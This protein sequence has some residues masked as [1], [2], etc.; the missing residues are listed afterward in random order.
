MD[1]ATQVGAAINAWLEGTARAAL[2]PAL[3]T[4]GTLVVA[5]P[6]L[7]IAPS[8]VS[9]WRLM[10]ALANALLVLAW[11]ACGV[12]VMSGAGDGRYAA[13]V[14]IPRVAFAALAANASLAVA[15]GL[16]ALNNALVAT[17]L[18][19]SAATHA[20][21]L[22]LITLPASSHDVL[23]VAL[24]LATAV[25]GVVLVAVAVI[26]D[27]VLI[28]A[29]A[30]APLALATSALPQTDAI[31]RGWARLFVAL[32]YVQVVQVVVLEI[33]SAILRAADPALLPSSG[34]VSGV[35]AVALV[36]VLARLPLMAVDAAL[37]T[38]ITVVPFARPV[39]VGLRALRAA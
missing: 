9:S 17:V 35:L 39:L 36:L 21:L 23:G 18:G 8:V 30:V 24:A 37:R 3:E 4:A 28:V 1:L 33:G 6:Q 32:L 29:T 14:L 11:L 19:Q 26:R 7:D 31:A 12:L 38:S 16:I 20:V 10:Q 2:G 13:K 5:T 22:D 25:L 34:L 27:L 15:G